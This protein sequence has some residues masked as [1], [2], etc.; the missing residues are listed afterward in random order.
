[1]NF[2]DSQLVAEDSELAV[3]QLFTRWRWVVAKDYIDVGYDFVVSPDKDTFKGARFCV[4]VKGTATKGRRS[5]VANVSK[6]RLRQYAE[7]VLPVFLLRVLPDGRI[8]WV[9]AQDWCQKNSGRLSGAGEAGVK[10]LEASV[11]SDEANFVEYLKPLMLP[12]AQRKGALTALANERA[13]YLSGIDK[14]LKVRVGYVNGGECYEI[15][16]SAMDEPF[17][18]SLVVRPVPQEENIAKLRDA[19]NYGLPAEFDAAEFKMTGS[20][21]FAELG[22]GT[23][24]TGR[25]SMRPLRDEDVQVTLTPGD[26]YSLTVRSVRIDSKLYRGAKGLAVIGDEDKLPLILRV[27]FDVSETGTRATFNLTIN[28]AG[29]ISSG[30]IASLAALD[31]YAEWFEQVTARDSV[32]LCFDFP[33][34]RVPKVLDSSAV[35]LMRPVFGH[36]AY[37]SKLHAIAKFCASDFRLPADYQFSVQDLDEIDTVYS[38]LRGGGVEI[39]LQSIQFDPKTEFDE[40][41]KSDF[42]VATELASKVLG[43]EVGTFPVAIQLHGFDLMPGSGQFKWQLKRGEEAA[44][45]LYYDESA[46]P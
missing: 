45:L 22:A 6:E 28:T 29:Y 39:G 16:S 21:L 43:M 7:C 23:G 35:S 31:G 44:S 17:K 32:W 26:R 40:A 14:R 9:H 11:L 33:N 2:P 25:I 36:M 19:F 34:A 4:Q 10:F 15:S 18:G 3:R 42:V 13:A 38:M 24:L 27:E 41:G 1:M 20:P 8:L 37:L 12:S 46:R 5:Y 30:P